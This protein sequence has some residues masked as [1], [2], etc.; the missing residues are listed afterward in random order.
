MKDVLLYTGDV[1]RASEE[2]K[3]LGGQVKQVF[4][5]AL[6]VAAVPEEAVLTESSAEPPEFVD[7]VTQMMSEAWH[8]RSRRGALEEGIRW[9]APGFEPPG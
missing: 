3:R 6:L 7:G 4:T 8:A 5:P 1:E 2:V 9:D